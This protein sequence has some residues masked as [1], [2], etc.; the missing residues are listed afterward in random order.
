[1]NKLAAAAASLALVLTACVN[2]GAPTK[3]TKENP[4]TRGYSAPLEVPPN[5]TAPKIWIAND[6]IIVDQEPIR[7]PG[8][9]QGDPVTI[10]FVLPD[11][12]PY[13]F[14]Q[15]GIEIHQ[16]PSFCSGVSDYIFRCAYSRPAPGTQYKYSVRVRKDGT[17]PTN[18][19]DLDPTIW[20]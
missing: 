20:N 3:Y 12:G 4:L 1:M 10:F 6:A 7:P 5:P 17:P 15:N 19:K 13:R 9:A 14:P 11:G 16:N 2:L 18:L 8:N